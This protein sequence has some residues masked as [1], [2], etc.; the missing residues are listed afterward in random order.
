MSA[1]IRLPTFQMDMPDNGHYVN[2]TAA[3]DSPDFQG[4]WH[5]RHSQTKPGLNFRFWNLDF[6]F[7]E[8]LRS[9]F[10]IDWQNTSNLKSTIKN[11][12]FLRSLREKPI[13]VNVLDGIANLKEM[14]SLPEGHDKCQLATFRRRQK[15]MP[16]RLLG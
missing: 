16:D 11:L 6:R 2:R 12:K 1:R 3:V 14:D 10:L 9:G 5:G 7:K 13:N 4:Y 8:S 15:A